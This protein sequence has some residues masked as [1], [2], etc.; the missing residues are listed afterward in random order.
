[1]V[2][3]FAVSVLNA[4]RIRD[5]SEEVGSPGMCN[6]LEPAKKHFIESISWLSFGI[7]VETSTR[8]WHGS[9]P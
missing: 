4:F 1:M 9:S 8:L 5:W 7:S 6:K 3:E 2:V